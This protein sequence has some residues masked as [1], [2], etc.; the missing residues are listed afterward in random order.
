MKKNN[1]FLLVVVDIMMNI[2]SSGCGVKKNNVVSKVVTENNKTYIEV[3]GKP[4]TYV[5]IQLRT[6]AFMNCEYKS[7]SD[8][9]KYFKLVADCNINTIQLPIDWRDV[10]IDE[11][12]YDYGVIKTFLDLANKHHLKAEFLWFGT[13]MCGETHTYHVPDYIVEN[14]VKYP[15]YSTDYT[16][17]FHKYYGYLLHLQFGHENLLARETKVA[18]NIM[19]YVNKWNEENGRPNT[20]IGI[21]VHNEPDCF[22]LWRVGHNQIQ[23]L[24]DGVQISEQEARDE[25]NTA[26]NE[27]GKAFKSGSYRVYTRVNFAL[28]NDMNDY[29]ESVFNLE[30]IDIVGD[31]PHNNNIDTI[32]YAINQYKLEGNYP[33]IAENRAA[34]ENTNSLILSSFANGGGYIM[35]EI[36]TS[37]FFIQNSG[38]GESNPD[39]GLYKSDLSKR[40]HTDDVAKFLKLLNDSGYDIVTRS[41]DKF[42]AFNI[43]TNVPQKDYEKTISLNDKEYTF[44]TNSGALG[45]LINCDDYLLVASTKNASL[46]NVSSTRVE[47]G[48]F[49]DGNFI[50]NKQI[51]QTNQTL[52]LEEYKIYK[53]TL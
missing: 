22:P 31:D 23:V 25:V 52:S 21:Q 36:A 16:G 33:H 27:V 29:I 28:A 20:L 40:S 32:S 4:Y 53:I 14:P 26:L 1:I 49:V 50:S 39:Y 45:Y 38:G 30:G 11:D 10:E 5:G 43:E 41:T 6:D 3:D 13:N 47:E 34:F 7:A 19:E 18:K 37:Q 51:E 8:L 35:Y 46:S 9:E 42:K 2:F 17:S 24:K 15:R 44:K 48:K 12:V